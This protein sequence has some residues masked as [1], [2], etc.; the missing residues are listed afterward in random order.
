MPDFTK[1][2]FFHFGSGD[3]SDPVGSLRASL[4]EASRTAR[5]DESLVVL[6]EA[7]NIKNGYLKGRFDPSISWSSLKAISL[8]FK[9]GLVAGLIVRWRRWS[10]WRYSCSYLIDGDVCKRLS[11]KMSDDRLG[12]YTASPNRDSPCLHRGVFIGS[13]IC[14]DATGINE[15][16][17]NERHNAL[18]GR[19]NSSEAT[20]KVLCVPA[21]FTEYDTL[22]VAKHWSSLVPIVIA[23]SY[24]HQPSVIRISTDE[25]SC[26]TG[27]QNSVCTAPFPEMP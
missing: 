7:F 3:Q 23:N 12:H 4:L 16:Y 18:L 22:G 1:I 14:M 19:F 11:C 21:H 24:A 6:P 13:L 5:L 17:P 2:G 27:F 26:I 10:S 20:R 8:E 9:V 25:T 15:N